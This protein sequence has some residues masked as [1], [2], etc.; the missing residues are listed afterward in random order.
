MQHRLPSRQKN[1]WYR[2]LTKLTVA[3]NWKFES[4]FLHRRVTSEPLAAQPH[5]T[6]R[7]LFDRFGLASIQRRVGCLRPLLVR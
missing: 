1:E 2:G 4:V 7:D 6:L 3:G 5:P